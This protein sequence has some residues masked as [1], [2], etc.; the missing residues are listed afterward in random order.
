M[1]SIFV[2]RFSI[3]G[4]SCT[5]A[6]L[7][8]PTIAVT[9]DKDKDDEH[10][11]PSRYETEHDE[12]RMGGQGALM[13][14]RTIDRNAD[15][16]IGDDEAAAEAETV[17]VTMDADDNGEITEAEYMAVRTGRGGGRNAARQ[18]M[19]QERKKVR[20]PQM[21]TDEDARVSKAE[22]LSA[23]Q[24]RFTASDLDG[25]G[26]VTPWEFRAHRRPF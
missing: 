10:E 1:K 18:R 9:D 5:V 14:F 13:R 19:M 3:L 20:F 23:A 25:D 4:A 16:I 15:G 26:T 12:Y 24:A 11:Y 22:F 6:L 7:A 8:L 21:D 17:F 2:K